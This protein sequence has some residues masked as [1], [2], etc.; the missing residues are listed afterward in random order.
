[1][2]PGH[3]ILF[4]FIALPANAEQQQKYE[5]K[6]EQLEQSLQRKLREDTEQQ[7]V[8]LRKEVEEEVIPQCA[9][10][11]EMRG[12]LHKCCNGRPDNSLVSSLLSL[13]SQDGAGEDGV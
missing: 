5:D 6:M 4:L 12:E 11:K 7:V 3:L 2:F 1:M 8:K 10:V 9:V 13:F